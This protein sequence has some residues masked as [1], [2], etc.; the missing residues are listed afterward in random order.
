MPVRRALGGLQVRNQLINVA[1]ALVEH[2]ADLGLLER[3]IKARRMER[4][5]QARTEIEAELTAAGSGSASALSAPRS[6][7]TSVRPESE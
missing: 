2:R 7:P 6:M 1:F 5:E 4:V 3:E